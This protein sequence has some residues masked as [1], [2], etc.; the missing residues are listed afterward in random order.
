MKKHLI[1][2]AVWLTVILMCCLPANLQGQLADG[3]DKFLGNVH[4]QGQTQ[5]NFD[6]YWNQL[7]PG[8]AGKW[9]SC[10]QSR[11]VH[12][13]WLWMD[14]AYNHAKEFGLPFKEHTLIWG[15]TSGD[16]T[17]MSSVSEDEQME[18]VL[19][20]FDTLS[21]RY[22]D[23]DYI[24]VVNE[25][26]HAPPVYT[27]ALGGD[28]ETG[29]DWVVWSFEKAREYFPNAVLILNDYNVLNYTS[30]CES[31]LEIIEILQER[32]LIDG[33][34]CQAHSLESI[35]LSTIQTNLEMLAAT[36]LDIYISEYEARGDDDTQLALYE[37]QFTYLWEHPSVKGITLW[38]YLEGYMWRETAYLLEDDGTTERPA[39]EWLREYFDYAPEDVQYQFNT[40][41][42]GGGSI[43][44][45]PAGGVYD[46]FTDV[47][48]TAV[49][50]SGYV[51]SSWSGDVSGS[52]NP[53]TLSVISNRSLTASFVEE[54]AVQTY[55]LSVSVSGN[56]SVTQSPTGTTFT[57]GTVVTL[58]A[59]PDDS[60]KF[61][62]WAGS[63][64]SS[65]TSIEVTMDEDKSLT[66]SFSE[67][68]G[69][70]CDSEESISINFSQDGTGEYCFV[71]DGE[72]THV[73]SWNLEYLEINGEDYTNKW[74]STLPESSDGKIHI[75]YYSTVDW[76]H[77]EISGTDSTEESAT[78]LTSNSSNMK[79][80]D[81]VPSATENL[82]KVYPNPFGNTA[83]L[84]I[85]NTEQ[86]QSIV[87]YN[88]L[89]KTV[90][91]YNK[92]D[93]QSTMT[94][95]ENLPSGIYYIR[96]NTSNSSKTIMTHKK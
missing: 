57:E 87:I 21:K 6:L 14:R 4:S 46:S 24:D 39:L 88:Q 72:V 81:A 61:D 52:T 75:Y 53:T 8:N 7:T 60:N 5:L 44:L 56:G 31:F 82:I 73:N 94:F 42:S 16:P 47:T 93:I 80:T 91:S 49:P 77:F 41:V 29:W 68:G 79:N 69:E 36:G 83:S 25:P 19:E 1:F 95:G 28:G 58:T 9:A 43:T 2:Q 64:S 48:A 30:T 89:G 35:T 26:L 90:E 18:E 40:H 76:G 92:A 45:D 84:Q 66:A 23:F 54:S 67:I 33:I 62:G 17:W 32:D 10:E 63:V 78:A 59:T 51:F 34:G 38:G 96:V 12:N 74:S 86:V 3:Q 11:D 55:S 15:G 37:E 65:E 13:T 71:A 27:E 22:P 85:G 50:D 70:G 20:W